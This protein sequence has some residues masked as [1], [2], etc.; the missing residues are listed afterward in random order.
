MIAETTGL[1]FGGE[2][3]YILVSINGLAPGS[4]THFLNPENILDEVYKH[5]LGTHGSATTS[6][7]LYF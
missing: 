2:L 7:A 1:V 4:S 6:C 5:V 3:P